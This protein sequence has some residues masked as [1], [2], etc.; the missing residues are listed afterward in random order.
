MTAPALSPRADEPGDPTVDGE[1]SCDETLERLGHGEQPEGLG[2][3]SAVDDDGVVGLG[4]V[5]HLEQGQHVVDARDRRD[6]GRHERV[7]A[8]TT[9]QVGEESA[10]GLPGRIQSRTGVDL[11]DVE[12]SRRAGHGDRDRGCSPLPRRTGGPG[13]P[14]DVGE[15]VRRVGAH[16]QGALSGLGGDQRGR[17]GHGRLADPTL[18]HDSSTRTGR[19]YPAG[20]RGRAGPRVLDPLLE[21]AQG[22]VDD[23]P[24]RPCA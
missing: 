19:T 7:H 23:A 12:R 17:C 9:E 8:D 3:G 4:P 6:L 15:R 11:E 20:T 1:P 14:E 18:A 5:G 2:C 16:D 10:H 13:E 22:R 24:S 21:P